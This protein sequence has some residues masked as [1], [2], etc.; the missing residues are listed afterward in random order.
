MIILRIDVA[1]AVESLVWKFHIQLS[2]VTEGM[3]VNKRRDLFERKEIDLIFTARH[4]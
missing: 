1:E 2:P 4:K 3:K